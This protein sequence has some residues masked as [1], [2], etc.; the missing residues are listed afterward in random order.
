MDPVDRHLVETCTVS[1]AGGN[2]LLASKVSAKMEV[3][4]GQGRSLKGYANF[5]VLMAR[6]CV[7]C[8]AA[9]CVALCLLGWRLLRFTNTG[10]VQYAICVHTDRLTSRS[11]AL[12]KGDVSG[13]E[14]TSRYETARSMSFQWYTNRTTD[15]CTFFQDHI[16]L[17]ELA[18]EGL[19][20]GR[21]P[22]LLVFD[23]MVGVLWKAGVYTCETGGPVGASSTTLW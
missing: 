16:Q 11:H 12:R 8:G 23:N 10:L 6:A 1:V 19:P 7:L 13:E 20:D 3:V 18:T 22:K 14:A 9:A 21:P 4:R 2:R 17:P 5:R 15:A